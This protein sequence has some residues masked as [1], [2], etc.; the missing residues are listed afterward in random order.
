M[1]NIIFLLALLCLYLNTAMAQSPGFRSFNTATGELGALQSMPTNAIADDFG[2]RNLGRTYW[3]GDVDFNSIQNDLN[4]FF[5]QTF[6]FFEFGF[7]FMKIIDIYNCFQKAQII[8]ILNL[9][10][11]ETFDIHLLFLA[12]KN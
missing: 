4:A 6:E 11:S 5:P 3:H 2:L 7:A 10:F 8:K 9:L 12:I 1:R